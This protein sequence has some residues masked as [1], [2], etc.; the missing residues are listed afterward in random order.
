MNTKQLNDTGLF[1]VHRGL[2]NRHVRIV[3]FCQLSQ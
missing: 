2:L 3:T 1:K